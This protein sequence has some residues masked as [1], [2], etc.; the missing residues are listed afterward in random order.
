MTPKE[1]KKMAALQAIKFIQPGMVIGLG[2][3]ST[4]TEFI[5]AIGKCVKEGL[6]ILG[7]PTSDFTRR[8]AEELG[9][10]LTTLR[11][12]PLP[13]LAVDGADELDGKLR[14][15]KGGGGALLRE[16]IVASAAEK[17]II[18]ADDSK[19][20]K[21]LGSF[22]LPIEVLPF[23]LEATIKLIR[24]VLIALN[25]PSNVKVRKTISNHSFKTDSDNM[26]VDCEL[27]RI[28]D[29]ETL[30][31]MLSAIPGVIEHGLFIGLAS[32]AIVAGDQ[33]VKILR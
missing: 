23:G 21:A 6:E 1:K 2:T 25:L 22:P 13:A 30:S 10:P 5:K 17:F 24:E 32:T 15:I 16:K 29:P 28:T 8:K 3:G 19:Y 9:I 7:I 14:L 27:S 18:I 20:V 26:V 31:A 4:A 12:H 33:G 11:A